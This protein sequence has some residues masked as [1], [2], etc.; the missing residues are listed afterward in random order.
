MT[1]A[2]SRRIRHVDAFTSTPLEGNPAAVVD[3]E[4]LSDDVMQRIALNQKLSETV[5]LWPPESPEN[6]AKL[7]IYTPGHEV[8]FAGHPTVAASHT[9]TEETL[10]DTRGG[11]L[12]LE[13]GAGVIPVDVQRGEPPLYT[14]TQAAPQ[15]RDARVSKGEIARC[16]GLADTDIG[17]VEFVSTGLEWLLAEI[18]SLEAMMRVV[19]DLTALD[20][21]A[22]A[23]FCVGARSPEAAVHVRAFA[24]RAGVP[25][26]P[27]TGSAN[28]CI[29]AFI[30]KHGLISSRDGEVAYVS[31]QGEEMGQPGR[32][33][34]RV[35]GVPDD[36]RA[37]V[38]G[39]AVT[40]L[41][42]ELLLDG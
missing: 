14:M 15:F 40:V 33:F 29:G 38:G 20:P 36:L 16:V 1:N 41:R 37:H 13:T 8:P 9:L 11:P 34:V 28:G 24:P 6:H 35:T 25:E 22:L 26:D 3:G 39:H 21:Y 31:E 5:F 2:R 18:S 17:R 42:G 32:V 19:P 23:I 30:A 7:R 10:V 27:V 12:R 4:G